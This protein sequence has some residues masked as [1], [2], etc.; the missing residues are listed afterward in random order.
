MMDGKVTYEG[1]VVALREM[2]GYDDSDFY[3]VVM[4]AGATEPGEVFYNT[5]RG[6][7]DGHAVVDATDEAAAAY[8][9]YRNRKREEYRAAVKAREDE[10][11]AAEAARPRRGD[12]VKV[13]KGRK[14]PK[15]TTG[16]VVWTGEGAYGPRVGLKDADG[17]VHFT[18]ESNVAKEGSS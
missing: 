13:V 2:N 7:M 15:G 16:S 18:A 10:A 4:P 11:A 3:A 14:V 9:S 12:T 17:V 1:Q 8:A 5:T 6:Y